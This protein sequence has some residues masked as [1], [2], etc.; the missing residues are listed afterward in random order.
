[1]DHAKAG[2]IGRRAHV[3]ALAY[4]RPKEGSYSATLTVLKGWSPGEN[5]RRMALRRVRKHEQNV[6]RWLVML[7]EGIA[8]KRSKGY[9]PKGGDYSQAGPDWLPLAQVANCNVG[10]MSLME[11]EISL[12]FGGPMAQ[13]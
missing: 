9:V 2:G 10:P 7:D 3:A 8:R 4:Q 1:M 12:R 5:Y 11:F 6:R 13:I